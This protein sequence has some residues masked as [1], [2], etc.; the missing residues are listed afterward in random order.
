MMINSFHCFGFRVLG[1]APQPDLHCA[2]W[3]WCLV[4][5]DSRHKTGTNGS[6]WDTSEIL[7][8]HRKWHSLIK[9]YFTQLTESKWKRCGVACLYQHLQTGSLSHLL[10][11]LNRI[12]PLLIYIIYIGKISG[13]PTMTS[14]NVGCEKG[15]FQ[16][17]SSISSFKIQTYISGNVYSCT[18]IFVHE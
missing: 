14:Q 8:Q 2:S 3:A 4:H 18:K 1:C 5:L 13:L 9:T 11:F 16:Y 17:F 6:A 7:Q 10:E 15:L 12:E